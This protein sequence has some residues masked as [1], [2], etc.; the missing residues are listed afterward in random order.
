MDKETVKLLEDSFAALAPQAD[1]LVARFYER[2]FADYPDVVSMFDGV[3]MD[4]QRKH[5]KAAL[6]FTVANLRK[7]EQLQRTLRELG[8]RHAEIGATKAHYTAVGSTLLVVL[9]ELAGNL[10]TPAIRDAWTTAYMTISDIMMDAQA[11]GN[12]TMTLHDQDHDILPVAA[13][14]VDSAG[15]VQSWNSAAE[16]LTGRS[17]DDVVG[18][19]A[20][21]AFGGKRR[22]TEVSSVLEDGAPFEGTVEVFDESGGTLAVQM[23]ANPMLDA[24]GEAVG[25][26]VVLVLKQG[27]EEAEF[28]RSATDGMLGPVVLVD[29]DFVVTYANEGTRKLF[30]THAE[31]FR[32]AFPGFDVSALVGTCIDTFHKNPMRIRRL[33]MES[34]MPHKADIQVGDLTFSLDVNAIRNGDEH[35]GFC[36]EWADV[37]EARRRALEADRMLSTFESTSACMMLCDDD[38]NIIYANDAV[39]NLLRTYEPELRDAF[40]GFSA[41]T[42]VG[43]NID[44]FHKNPAHQRALLADSSRLPFTAEIELGRILFKIT[45]CGVTD[46][47]GQRVGAAVEWLD[48]TEQATYGREVQGLFEACKAGRLDTRADTSQFGETYRPMLEAVN[49]IIDVTVAPI[50]KI[51]SHLEEVSEGDL[52]AKVIADY[53]GDHGA[54]KDAL[55]AT[56]DALNETLGQ[57]NEVSEGVASGSRQVSDTAQ[58]LSAGATQQAASLRQITTTMAQ[59]TDQ[60]KQNAENATVAS[61][62]SNEAR[63]VAVDGDKMMHGMVSA[64]GEIDESSQSIR[65]II[66]VIDEIAFQTNLLALNAAV[67]AARAGVHGKGFAV[68]AEEVRSLAARSAKAAKETTELIEDSLRKVGQGTTIANQTAEALTKIV[69]GVGKVTDLVAEIAAASTEQANGIKDIND[70]LSQV[71]AVTQTNTAAAEESAAASQELSRQSGDL[72]SKL[73]RFKLARSQAGGGA[74]GDLPPD[75]LEAVARFIAERD[76]GGPAANVVSHPGFAAASGS[77]YTDNRSPAEV[78]PLDDSEFGKF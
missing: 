38:L 29:R 3:D 37:T 72:R 5:L 28:V 43:T 26:S 2:L 66:K 41:D 73:G 74:T 70:G 52:T 40:P 64:M 71:E 51:R 48:L 57:V 6:A 17:A 18:K 9:E 54:L 60:T 35:L 8:V 22:R 78:L 42:L 14:S 13:F 1:V 16:K 47:D 49:E 63:E 19:K 4:Q 12:K 39:A 30:E 69:G 21:A 36:L 45:A 77:S 58:S 11:Q 31:A 27:N 23:M 24:D 59:I 53:Q 62:L 44:K 32:T 68:V 20:W 50:T 15:R 56:L 65:K 75:V 25:A 34:P 67:E 46:A 10:W 7:P 76:G 55:N 61:T 33:L